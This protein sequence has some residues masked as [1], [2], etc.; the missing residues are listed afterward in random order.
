MMENGKNN[1]KEGKGIFNNTLGNE[2]N[3][4]WKNNKKNGKK[5]RN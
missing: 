5:K 1:M 3:G 4:E 2:Y